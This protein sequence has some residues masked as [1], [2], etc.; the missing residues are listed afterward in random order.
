MVKLLAID[1]DLIAESENK[2]IRQLAEENKYKLNLSDLA[3]A[4]LRGA[5]LRGANLRW[6]DLGGARL[7]GAHIKDDQYYDLV[8]SIGLII[9]D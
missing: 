1:G 9:E 2:N 8:I 3:G 4:D 6:A 7:N 5:D